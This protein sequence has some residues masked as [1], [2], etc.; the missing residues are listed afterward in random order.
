MF[1]LNILFDDDQKY[2]I[3]VSLTQTQCLDFKSLTIQNEMIWALNFVKVKEL[4]CQSKKRKES[5]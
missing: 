2:L 3:Y 1:E 4:E 5:L